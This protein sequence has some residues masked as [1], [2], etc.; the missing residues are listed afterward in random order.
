MK[1]NLDELI[2]THASKGEGDRFSIQ[3]GEFIKERPELKTIVET[4]FGISSLFMVKG[5]SV[6]AKLYSID[7]GP[8]APF[9]I[10]HPNHT[11]INK[12]S[13]DAILDLY[14][15]VGPFD[16]VLTDG[17]HSCKAQTY[18]Y[19]V[20]WEFLKPGCTMANDDISWSNHGSFAKF[21]KERGL[22]PWQMGDLWC[23]TKPKEF[24]FCPAAKAKE[25]HE[26]WLEKAEADQNRFYA[27]GGE[28][29][30]LFVD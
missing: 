23:V 18:E 26:F 2:T 24:G 25:V 7:T 8:W 5:M 12:R 17:S 16:L 14:F 1:S 6:D 28:V 19:N 9:M 4:G 29:D 11:F 15:L 3:L 20:L 10:D 27:T 13:I 30:T 22:T 21:V